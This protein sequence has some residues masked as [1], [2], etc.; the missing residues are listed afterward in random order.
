LASIALAALPMLPALPLLAQDSDGASDAVLIS[1]LDESVVTGPP[2]A[3]PTRSPLILREEAAQQIRLPS[4]ATRTVL[5]PGLREARVFSTDT[6]DAG[7]LR[8]YQRYCVADVLRQTPGVSVVSTGQAGSQTSLFIRGMESNHAVVLLNGRRLP[9]GLAGI[10]QLEF[11]ETSTLDSVQVHRGAVSSLYGSDALAGAIDL[12]STD[13]RLVQGDSLVS[14]FEGGSF[15]TFR[16]GHKGTLRDGRLRLAFDASYHET[17]NDRPSSAY[18]NGV[19]RGNAAYELGDGVFIDVLGYVQDATLQVPG[20]SLGFAFPEPQINQNQSSMVSPR[21]SIVRDEWDLSVFYSHTRNE[22]LATRD[23]FFFD[24]RLDQTGH[25]IGAQLTWRPVE[26]VALTVG[27]GHYDY[28]FERTP[29]IPGPFNAPAAFSYAY[30]SVFAQAEAALPYGFDLLVSGRHDE[31]DAFASK[32]TYSAQLSRTVEAIGTTVHGKVATGYKAPSGQDFIF[33][34]PTLDPGLIPPEE[35]L[36]RELGIR[37]ALFDQ[38]GTLG[39]TYFWNDAENLVDVDPFTFFD[40]AIVDTKADG[41]E[42]EYR[43]A[44][45]DGLSVYAN[46]T[47]LRATVVDGFYLGGFAGMPGDRLVRR[48]EH[49][50]AAGVL[51]HGDGWTLGAELRGAYRRFDSADTILD[52]CTVARIFGS[53]ELREGI[54]VYGRIENVFDLDYEHTAG[55]EAAGIGAFAGLRLTF[56]Q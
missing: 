47:R 46:Y 15:D 13:A 19:V 14:Y 9:P 55:Y 22:L 12:R 17:S 33:L 25:E 18:E 53:Y 36:T 4:V 23:L 11:L 8:T 24:N 41:F 30:S 29:L 54:E 42:I 45:N 48:P 1:T 39:F 31:H 34:D 20:S 10:Y 40:P 7:E 38:R 51:A 35:S 27:G 49:T 32:A 37:Q 52:D 5:A 26:E 56:G 16:T 28:A 44:L 50:L 6:F 21:F 2:S 43:H 3:A